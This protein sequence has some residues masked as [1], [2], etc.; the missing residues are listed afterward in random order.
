[1]AH[2]SAPAAQADSTRATARAAGQA[3][4]GAAA[5]AAETYR[6]DKIAVLRG[7]L[8]SNNCAS[9][10]DSGQIEGAAAPSAPLPPQTSR[11]FARLRLFVLPSLLLTHS[12]STSGIALKQVGHV[13]SQCWVVLKVYEE[14]GRL[15]R[16][17]LEDGALVPA[18]GISKAAS[19]ACLLYTSPSPRDS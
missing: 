3:A 7:A 11:I 10:I 18:G 16:A 6:K 1:M 13:T 2:R 14:M 5:R 17:V 9:F 19:C 15:E 4:A 8:M 12:V